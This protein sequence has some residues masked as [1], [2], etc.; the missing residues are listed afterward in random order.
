[1][2]KRRLFDE[3]GNEIKGKMKKPFY[4]KWWF[5]LLV[6]IVVGNALGG[7]KDDTELSDHS[8]AYTAEKNVSEEPTE[9]SI[10]IESESIEQTSEKS[11][12]KITVET[13]EEQYQVILD[14]YTLKIKE[15]TPMLVEEYNSEY[16]N[17]EEGLEGLANLSNQK[18]GKLAEISNE[19]I[20]KMA[21]VHFSKGS[22]KYEDYEEWAGK[23]MDVYM[24]EGEQITDAYMNSAQ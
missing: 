13:S 2:A 23:L 9:S 20:G 6:I 14:D 19:G 12:T 7:G 11:I 17:N 21:E 16:P 10:S 8:G 18:I 24:Q 15:A 4:K 3:H 5:W 22:G 1:M